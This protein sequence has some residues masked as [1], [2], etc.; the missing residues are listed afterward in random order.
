[1]QDAAAAMLIAILRNSYAP[2]SGTVPTVANFVDY[3][4][5]LALS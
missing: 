3:L 2:G 4:L 1:M 5:V